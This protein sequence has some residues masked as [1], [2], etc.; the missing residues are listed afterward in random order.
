MNV[1]ETEITM[2][3]QEKIDTHTCPHYQRSNIH[4][5]IQLNRRIEFFIK[6][7]ISNTKHSAITFTDAV[8]CSLLI[9]Y[10]NCTFFYIFNRIFNR[11]CLLDQFYWFLNTLKPNIQRYLHY[12]N[13]RP[14]QEQK[15]KQ[16]FVSKEHN[17]QP[18]I[19][20]CVF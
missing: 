16:T 13:I 17:N 6:W 7:L 10:T 18:P 8:Y 9:A 1:T 2:S 15:C 14:F 20:R 5:H 19:T 4:I 3:N 11:F 12:L